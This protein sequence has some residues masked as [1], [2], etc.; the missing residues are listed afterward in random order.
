MADWQVR[1]LGGVGAFIHGAVPGPGGSVLAVGSASATQDFFRPV[2]AFQQ[3]SGG[4]TD[5]FVMAVTQAIPEAVTLNAASYSGPDVAPNSIATAFHAEGEVVRV[6]VNAREALILSAAPGQTSFVVPDAQET[7][8]AEVILRNDAGAELARGAV[9]IEPVAP[10]IFTANADGRGAPAAQVIRV[11]RSTGTPTNQ[12]PFE[13]GNAGACTPAAVAASDATAE[14]VLVLYGTG[15]RSRTALSSVVAFIDGESLPVDYAG[16][17]P[18]FHGLDQ[19]NFRLPA[20][21][22]GRGLVSIVVAVDGRLANP[23]RL[24]IL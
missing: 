1:D 15:L 9:R 10:A 20:T 13:C 5:A 11:D 6:E 22:Q 8:T 18:E 14:S 16:P 17:Q 21:L 12:N 3:N 2:D 19:V 24:H 4:L 23:V 7:G